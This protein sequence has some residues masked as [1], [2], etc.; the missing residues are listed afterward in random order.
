MRRGCWSYQRWQ[1]ALCPI[2]P[3]LWLGLSQDLDPLTYTYNEIGNIQTKWNQA[4]SYDP[5]HKHAVKQV[6]GLASFSY[7]ANGNMSQ[8]LIHGYTYNLTWT[9]ENKLKQ[10]TWSGNT[11]TFTYDGDGNRLIKNHNGTKTAYIGNY[12]EKTG[13]QETK[14]YYHNGQRVA[15][16]NNSGVYYFYNDPANKH[17]SSAQPV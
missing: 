8:R 10:V 14:Y 17:H 3:W 7:D 9:E 4:F 2:Q 13:S 15:M 11:V 1:Q 5:N 6:I 12:F 16:R